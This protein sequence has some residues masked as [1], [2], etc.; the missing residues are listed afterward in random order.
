MRILACVA[1]ATAII[2]A[3]NAF[4]EPEAGQGYFSVMGSYI[5]DDPARLAKDGINGLQLG[6]GYAP[7]DAW[8]VEVFLTMAELEGTDS[9]AYDQGQFG[10]GVDLQRVFR[11]A[12][13]FS[14]YLHVGLGYFQVSPAG[15]VPTM[16]GASYSGGAGFVLDL[17]DSNVALRGDWTIRMDSAYPDE[18]LTDNLFSLGLQ[19]PFGPKTKKWVDTDGDGVEDSSDRCPNTPRGAKVDMYGCELDSDGDGVKDSKDQCPNTPAG[20]QVDAVGCPLPPVD[21][22]DDKDGVLNSKDQCPNTPAGAQVDVKGCEIK[23]EIKLH[24]VNFQTNSD[25]LLPGAEVY[26]DEAAA[27]LKKNPTIKVEVAGYTDSQGAAEYNEGLSMRRAQTV[28]DYLVSKGIAD[29]RMSVRGYGEADPIASNETAE[30]RAKNRR[31]TLRIV[32]R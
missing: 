10:L 9:S 17:G 12:E 16:E 24:G 1:A 31:V 22:D 29:D 11:R 18:D 13:K 26:L 6:M 25:R 30:G 21:G 8:N 5:D 23:E 27:T 19:I 7:N 20:T 14:P 2:W 4:A 28:H 3:G 15:S 32:D